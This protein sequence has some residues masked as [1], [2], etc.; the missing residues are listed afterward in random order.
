MSK[1]LTNLSSLIPPIRPVPP[2]LPYLEQRNGAAQMEEVRRALGLKTTEEEISGVIAQSL[3]LDLSFKPFEKK[4]PI[5]ILLEE[6]KK[7]ASASEPD[8]ENI[9]KILNQVIALDPETPWA[10]F[11]RGQSLCALERHEDAALD[12][13][14]ELELHEDGPGVFR[15]YFERAFCNVAMNK[16]HLAVQDFGKYEK[17][18]TS[19]EID[20]EFVTTLRSKIDDEVDA[21]LKNARTKFSEADS[22]KLSDFGEEKKEIYREAKKDKYLTSLE[23]FN[24]LVE[25]VPEKLWVHYDRGLNLMRLGRLEEAV[26]DFEKELEINQSEHCKKFCTY[27]KAIA[28]NVLRDYEKA[29]SEF[30]YLLQIQG[31]SQDPIF[32]RAKKQLELLEAR[33]KV[34]TVEK[35]RGEEANYAYIVPTATA[36][37][38]SLVVVACVLQQG[39]ARNRRVSSGHFRDEKEAAEYIQFFAREFFD[40]LPYEELAD[41]LVENFHRL[42]KDFFQRTIKSSSPQ[43]LR[44]FLDEQQFLNAEVK[45]GLIGNFE[46]LKQCEKDQLPKPFNFRFPKNFLRDY[47]LKESDSQNYP[48]Y[49]AKM[50]EAIRNFEEAASKKFQEICENLLRDEKIK[51]LLAGLVSNVED[52][53]IAPAKDSYIASSEEIL[54]SFGEIFDSETPS[55]SPLTTGNA[56]PKFSQE[57]VDLGSVR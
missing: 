7:K 16:I 12:F 39:N 54:E 27:E 45:E 18:D 56:E 50:A 52:L 26:F 30:E 47:L 36:I 42:P 11:D 34:S 46:A 14:R 21:L 57:K 13:T 19:N 29:K 15:S 43:E 41:H 40:N 25:C 44:A 3:S 4:L 9:V 2:A 10:H 8:H 31:E 48:N 22:L 5:E 35:Q 33:Q 20:A 24:Q 32:D 17:S 1:L 37:Y 23:F 28:H 38:L 51:P 49:P 55:K 53:L 6:V